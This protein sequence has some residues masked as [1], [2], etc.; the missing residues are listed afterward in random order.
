MESSF[1]SRFTKYILFSTLK[2]KKS[3]QHPAISHVNPTW[4]HTQTDI[5]NHDSLA[6]MGI[7]MRTWVKDND[8]TDFTSTLPYTADKFSPTSSLCYYK[9]NVDEE[10]PTMMPTELL[11]EVY[12][13]RRYIT[14]VMN[15]SDYDPDDPDFYHYHS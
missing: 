11:Q 15:E 5:L 2:F 12:N 7:K 9:E 8:M 13:F 4:E 6:Q 10:T 3:T 14:H 1:I